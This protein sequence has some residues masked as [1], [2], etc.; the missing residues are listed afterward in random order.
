MV[1]LRD[2]VKPADLVIYQ[3]YQDYQHF[4]HAFGHLEA[5]TVQ[6]K[7]HQGA[8]MTLVERL[9][10]IEIILNIQQKSTEC[11][12]KYL[13]QWLSQQPKHQSRYS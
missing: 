10:K 13:E 12:N 1:T 4:Q 5:D 8:V 7:A 2:V 6:G 11:V 9:S 3:R